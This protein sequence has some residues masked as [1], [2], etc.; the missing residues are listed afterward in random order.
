MLIFMGVFI[1]MGRLRY[2]KNGYVWNIIFELPTWD[3]I[4][5]FFHK[6]WRSCGSNGR[7]R[8]LN[9]ATFFHLLATLATQCAKAM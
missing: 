4:D 7:V 6:L 5:G 8:D 1:I 9:S 2:K 3:V